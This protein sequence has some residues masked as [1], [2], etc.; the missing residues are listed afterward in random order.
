MYVH[1]NVGCHG[2]LQ[3]SVVWDALAWKSLEKPGLSHRIISLDGI[4]LASSC[5]RYFGA[6]LN[7]ICP[8]NSNMEP[9]ICHKHNTEKKKNIKWSRNLFHVFGS[10]T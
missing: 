6:I 4:T 8:F 9:C 1:I 2:G 3:A 7:K 10:L 5:V